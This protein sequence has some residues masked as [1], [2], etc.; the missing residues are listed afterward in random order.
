V[1]F[2]FL[3]FLAS[4]ALTLLLYVS[5][6]VVAGVKRG[7]LPMLFRESS[8]SGLQAAGLAL[9][10]WNVGAG[11][12]LY[13]AVYPIHVDMHV[14]SE[15]ALQ[16]FSRGYTTRLPIVVLPYGFACLAWACALWGASARLS[17][18]S[19]WIVATLCV[20]SVIASPFAANAQG[21]MQE[22]G[23]SDAAYHQLML[24]HLVRTLAITVAAAWVSV[25][26]WRLPRRA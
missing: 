26:V 2:Y 9:L 25:Q 11:W 12:L 18:R 21:D 4:L 8:A 19:I 13:L 17:R 23:F 16:V 22:H 7:Q 14:L 1:P 20:I 24:A 5:A 3:L 10:W 15:S 6:I